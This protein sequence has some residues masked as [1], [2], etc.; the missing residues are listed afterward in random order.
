MTMFF[1]IKSYA[2]GDCV[3]SGPFETAEAAKATIEDWELRRGDVVIAQGV[4]IA[5]TETI[6]KTSWRKP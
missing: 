6:Y 5:E 2:D 1:V 3:A 4:E